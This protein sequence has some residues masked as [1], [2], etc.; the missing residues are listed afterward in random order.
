MLT[1]LVT[2]FGGRVVHGVGHSHPDQIQDYAWT[3][4]ITA[5]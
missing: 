4:D 1:L 2:A 3:C 5:A